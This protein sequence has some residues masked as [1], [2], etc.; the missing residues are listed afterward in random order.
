[1]GDEAVIAFQGTD[2]SGDWFTNLDKNIAPPPADAV[3]GGFLEAYR[4]VAKQVKGAL[5]G[6]GIKHAWVTGHS[7]GGAMAVVCAIDLVREGKVGVRGVI[8]FGQPLLLAP[9]FAPEANGLLAGRFLRLIHEDDLVPRIVP[10]FRGGGSSMWLK[11]GELVFNGPRMRAFAANGD[12]AA[13]DHDD[14]EAGPQPL[15]DE[16]FEMEKARRRTSRAAPSEPAP[17]EPPRMQALPNTADHPMTRYLEA[18]KKRFPQAPPTLSAAT[19][20]A[21]ADRGR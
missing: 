17:G 4:S 21:T 14:V 20:D 19:T 2:D 6:A 1:M 16:E 9:S 12:D 8:T 7:L 3:H 11:N 5:A 13:A 18:I 10:G 15:T